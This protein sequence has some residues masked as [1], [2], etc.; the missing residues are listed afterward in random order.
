MLKYSVLFE[1]SEKN[2]FS[3]FI[4]FNN[5]VICALL[6]T[7]SFCLQSRRYTCYSLIF[8]KIFANIVL[9]FMSR[10]HAKIPSDGIISYKLLK[11]IFCLGEYYRSRFL[12]CTMPTLT[13]IKSDIRKCEYIFINRQ[14]GKVSK[15]KEFK[16]AAEW[17]LKLNNM[18]IFVSIYCFR[19]IVFFFSSLH[20]TS[21][22]LFHRSHNF[23]FFLMWCTTSA[24]AAYSY[25]HRHKHRTKIMYS[26]REQL[27]TCT[28]PVLF[29]FFARFRTTIIERE[30]WMSAMASEN[31]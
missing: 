27:T 26:P 14:A 8:I 4:H 7:Y 25:R 19:K 11:M 13:R 31:K 10:G 23:A 21:S 30:Y 16:I 29:L 24:I 22:F 20:F 15:C 2:V 3:S 18:K 1:Q 9:S 17:L 6:Y 12:Q 28:V 5:S